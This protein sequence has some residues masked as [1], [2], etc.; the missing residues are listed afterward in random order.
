M[1]EFAMSE[2]EMAWQGDSVKVD[3]ESIL[4]GIISVAEIKEKTE[5]LRNKI[6]QKCIIFFL[7][8]VENRY[9]LVG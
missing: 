1:F 3:V 2:E 4:G 5:K 6:N 9:C 8:C 7:S